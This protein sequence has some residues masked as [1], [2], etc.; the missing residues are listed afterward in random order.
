LTTK[1]N[2]HNKN[3]ENDITTEV[4]QEET[5]VITMGATGFFPREAAITFS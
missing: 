5:Y 3:A 1:K 4:I 2:G